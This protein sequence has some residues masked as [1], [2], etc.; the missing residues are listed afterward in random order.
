MAKTLT[1]MDCYATI[2]ELYKLATGTEPEIS[3]VDT[4]TFVSVGEAL[5]STGKENVLN[6]LSLLIGRTIIVR[7]NACPAQNC[8]GNASRDCRK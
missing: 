8:G 2:N 7:R 4:S 3:A 5:M 6:A 1:P